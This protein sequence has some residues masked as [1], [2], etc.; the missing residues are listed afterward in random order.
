MITFFLS[1]TDRNNSYTRIPLVRKEDIFRNTH[2]HI[3]SGLIVKDAFVRPRRRFESLGM[4]GRAFQNSFTV[5][6]AFT[7][8]RVWQSFLETSHETALILEEDAVCPTMQHILSTIRQIDRPW[9]FLQ[10]GRCWDFCESE[11]IVFKTATFK[12]VQSDSSCC[13]HAY[14][15]TRKAAKTLLYYSLPYLTSVDLLFTLLSRQNILKLYSL[16]PILC[17]QNRSASAHDRT[18]ILE[19]DPN[20]KNLKKTLR[21][22][23]EYAVSLLK[24][25][26][27]HEF[28]SPFTQP[29]VN[30]NCRKM[31]TYVSGNRTS[32]LG[33][34]ILNDMKHLK[35][36]VIWDSTSH[37]DYQ[38]ILSSIFKVFHYV[39]EHSSQK[40]HLCW[41]KKT[42][43]AFKRSLVLA[44]PRES[45]WSKDKTFHNLHFDT[46]NRYLFYG[47]IPTRFRKNNSVQFDIKGANMKVVDSLDFVNDIKSIEW[48]ADGF[49]DI[50]TKYKIS[51]KKHSVHVNY[52]VPKPL[53]CKFVEQCSLP[54]VKYGFQK[55]HC[56]HKSYVYE[57]TK[58]TTDGSFVPVLSYDD[59]I[60]HI[61]YTA[62]MNSQIIFTNNRYIKSKFNFS[63]VFYENASTFCDR[64]SS[65]SVDATRLK[66]HVTQSHLM[67]HRV[68]ELV[69]IKLK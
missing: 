27:I 31:C 60:P 37:P 51:K 42:N 52:D 53:F 17:F 22:R 61:F 69:S 62:A 13:S 34:Q 28:M 38:R 10:L 4:S 20:E 24:K 44:S 48:G 41:L 14:I 39:F 26:W 9:D 6:C 7:H 45:L 50:Q 56:F 49:A 23:D 40:M 18:R 19:C 1:N 58:Q 65:L 68:A 36:F 2:R 8:R 5:A 43:C 29:F 35:G 11:R 25:S 59:F 3:S 32:N 64:V 21:N 30:S 57:K 66:K 46:S 12:L 15:I 54:V 16:S 55:Y 67:I 33:L 63:S 47:S